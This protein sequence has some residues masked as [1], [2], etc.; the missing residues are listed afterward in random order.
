MHAVDFGGFGDDG[1]EAFFD[2][3]GDQP[4]PVLRAEDTMLEK[5]GLRV[6]HLGWLIW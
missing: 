2:F 4:F 1:T 3:W 6:G 5:F